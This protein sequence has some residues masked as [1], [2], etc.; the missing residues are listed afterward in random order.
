MGV[1]YIQIAGAEEFKTLDKIGKRKAEEIVK[2]RR[3]NGYLTL[4]ILQEISGISVEGWKNWIKEGKVAMQVPQDLSWFG[5]TQSVM[6]FVESI[7]NLQSLLIE[8]QR[9]NKLMSKELQHQKRMYERLEEEKEESLEDAN[10]EYEKFQYQTKIER[11][12]EIAD[13]EKQKQ[14]WSC[15][16]QKLKK[17]LD[18]ERA[19]REEERELHMRSFNSR[20]EEDQSEDECERE[21]GHT[22][23]K[24]ADPF[25]S[26][27]AKAIPPDGRYRSKSPDSRSKSK[28]NS[29]DCAS[30]SKS[31]RGVSEREIELISIEDEL[32][33]SSGM[34]NFDKQSAIG[35]KGN[36]GDA[37]IRR[38][39]NKSRS[40]PRPRYSSYSDNSSSDRSSDPSSD[41]DDSS[42]ERDT[43]HKKHKRTRSRSP[44]PPKMSVFSGEGKSTWE[45][46][47]FQFERIAKR[48]KWK[49][50]KKVDRLFDCL[51]DTA[52][53]YANKLS[54]KD[55]YKKLKKEMKH[56][57]SFKE[58]PTS[59]RRQLQFVKQ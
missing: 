46:F 13:M 38:N 7:D 30:N 18:R 34:A 48:R 36:A 21:T 51:S 33:H 39:R 12:A 53:E 16:M 1:V 9:K 27:V 15:E 8:E 35:N 10:R 32:Q 58:A 19:L 45:S 55:D 44:Q 37:H 3:E 14:K 2:Y 11:N 17:S 24:Y 47:I 23:A 5:S 4:E 59:A 25:V 42:S 29:P 22:Y 28:S 50:L 41:S 40:K 20:Q 56:R 26:K 57:F 49:T 43:R 52:L 31:Q 6:P 54:C